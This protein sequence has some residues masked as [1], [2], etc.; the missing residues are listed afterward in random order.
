MPAE[1]CDEKDRLLTQKKLFLPFKDVKT[2]VTGF[3]I[4]ENQHY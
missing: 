3:S 4:D 1:F 2:F